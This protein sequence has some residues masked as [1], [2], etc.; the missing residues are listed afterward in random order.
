MKPSLHCA[1]I[2][3]AG[4][5]F[6]TRAAGGAEDPAAAY[7]A[8]PSDWVRLSDLASQSPIMRRI[9][10]RGRLVIGTG[11]EY[12]SLNSR[13]SEGGCEGLIGDYGKALAAR[14]LGDANKVEWRSTAGGDG[15]DQVNRGEVDLI[16]DPI[17]KGEPGD[18]TAR[19]DF[20]AEFLR[21]GGAI[22]IRKSGSFRSIGDIRNSTRILY[23]KGAAKDVNWLRSN[24]PK[25]TYVEFPDAETA[26]AALKA[27]QGDFVTA[28]VPVLYDLASRD[29]D[30]A[31]TSRYTD[32]PYSMI[33]RRGDPVWHRYLAGFNEDLRSSGGYEALYRKWLIPLSGEM[34]R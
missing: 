24:A 5:G 20:V 15:F 16:I 10:D 2:F 18:R 14:M 22:L 33:I 25:A 19:M 31:P 23:P 1:L 7:P 3:A 30:Y 12:R 34:L 28:D 8:T 4:A 6:L 9:I 29:H 27:G 11:F 26:F 17:P 13:S 21:G 32:R